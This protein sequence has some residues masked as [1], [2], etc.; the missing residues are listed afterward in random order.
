MIFSRSNPIRSMNHP[1][2]IEKPFR[3]Y[4]ISSLNIPCWFVGLL[5]V[6]GFLKA[7]PHVVGYERF[8]DGAVLY[9]ELGCANCHGGSAVE[10]PRKGPNLAALSLRVRKEWVA[11]FLKDPENGRKGSTMPHMF[12]G[13]PEAERE[14]AITD[15]MAWL[16]TRPTKLKIRA[17]RH[18]NAEAGSAMYHEKGCGA[19]HAATPDFISPH[20]KLEKFENAI[21]HPDF[22]KKTDVKGL[23][24][25]LGNISTFRPDGR[26]PHIQ[27]LPEEASDIAAH[28]WDDQASVP[29][30]KFDVRTWTKADSDAIKRGGEWV[31]KLNCASCH[32]GLSEQ[33]AA[34]I[35]PISS[36]A[37]GGCLSD[38]PAEGRPFYDLSEKQ[39]ESLVA[40]LKSEKQTSDDDGKL[41]L[42]AMNCY[43]C[44]ER[45]G[46]GG[47]VVET[48]SFFIGDEGLGDSGRLAP[49]LTGIGHKLKLEWIE[50]VFSG[51]EGSR[52]RDYVKTQMPK[53]PAQ[54]KKMAAW[55]SK[56]DSNPDATPI[57]KVEDLEAGQKLLGIH[58]GVNCI[59]CHRWE[60][61]ASLGIQAMDISNLDQRLQPSWFR[62]YL[63]NPASYRPGTLMPPLWPGG[64]SMV[65]DVAGGDAETQIG[66]IWNFIKNGEGVPEGFPD[67]ASGAFELIP[68]DR[69]IIQRTFLNKV[70]T[71]AILVG[72]PGEVN[73]AIDGASGQPA[74]V[75]KGKFF[76]G[77]DTFF[78][79]AAPFGDPLEEEVFEFEKS[80][81]PMRFRGYELDEKGNPTFLRSEDGLE[82][83]ERFSG[84]DGK[85]VRTI[86]WAEGVAEPAKPIHPVGVE[87]ETKSSDRAITFTYFSK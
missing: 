75:W 61:R 82:V 68:K 19:C 11:D 76:D 32:D 16:G 25:F 46:I 39:R 59:T 54:A 41:T 23:A 35:K 29:D 24:Y 87:F 48:N 51:T 62:E 57:A 1:C 37:G 85:L 28:L 65:P 78:T 5:F 67:R 2:S 34:L 84:E 60:E 66:A 14:T 13:I 81:A 83:S 21:S 72:F 53:Y 8:D 71:K 40:F 55:L 10:V 33:K 69:P 58:G 42:A 7:E 52:V 43:A 50:S 79:R 63:L 70:G 47:P 30:T 20:G 22:R 26:M 73:I 56:I 44:H 18:T 36:G 64:K 45:D 6:S 27:L 38:E 9:S 17:Q 31:N 12:D 15:V 77:Y 86:R 4:P 3:T 74:L 80:T 49:P